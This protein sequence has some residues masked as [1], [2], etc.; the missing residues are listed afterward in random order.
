MA[1]LPGSPLDR[2]TWRLFVS[3]Q[4]EKDLKS[5]NEYMT[6]QNVNSAI[7]LDPILVL[8]GVSPPE[9]TTLNPTDSHAAPAC[10][11]A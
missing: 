10:Q 9:R 8:S 3:F 11:P 1:V 6:N 4:V 2:I 5:G 7:P